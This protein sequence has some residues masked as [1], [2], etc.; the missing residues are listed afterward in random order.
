MQCSGGKAR[1]PGQA[2]TRDD[3]G[4]RKSFAKSERENALQTERSER[5][6]DRYKPKI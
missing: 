6:R 5:K 4:I 1:L 2:D 3:V